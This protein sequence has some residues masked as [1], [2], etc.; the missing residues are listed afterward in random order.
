MF[1]YVRGCLEA[2]G[3]GLQDGVQKEPGAYHGTGAQVALFNAASDLLRILIYGTR[4]S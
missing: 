2:I 1:G 4:R 3:R